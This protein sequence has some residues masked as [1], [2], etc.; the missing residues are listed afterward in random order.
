MFHPIT[1]VAVP[2]TARQPVFAAAAFLQGQWG[3]SSGSNADTG[4]P[5]YSPVDSYADAQIIKADLACIIKEPANNEELEDIDNIIVANARVIALE[6]AGLLIE[7]TEL[8]NRVNGDFTGATVGD[9][10]VL[11]VSGFPTLD[12]ASD[13]PG[14]AA[15]VVAR[16]RSYSGDAVIYVT[17]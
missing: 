7:D 13:D 15:T 12:G 6:G 3:W 10:M 11:T 4:D 8:G 9:A 16:F 2:D 1:M 17:Q 14:A 5:E